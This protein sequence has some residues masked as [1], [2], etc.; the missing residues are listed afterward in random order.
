MRKKTYFTLGQV[1][2]Q[3]GCRLWQV[4]RLFERG[5]LPEPER[6]GILRVVREDE[7]P[8]IRAALERCG[9]VQVESEA[10]HA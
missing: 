4:A 6:I 1:A 2:K 10:V 7:L 3:C 8:A 9:Y 5:I